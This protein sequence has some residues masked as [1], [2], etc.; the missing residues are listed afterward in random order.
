MPILKDHLNCDPTY[1]LEEMIIEANPLHKK[2]KR[3]AK[4]SSRRSDGHVNP[5]E[6]KDQQ[7]AIEEAF[8]DFHAFN[9]ERESGDKRRLHVTTSDSAIAHHKID[10]DQD[11][12]KKA[13][14]KANSEGATQS[15]R[16]QSST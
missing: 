11:I 9:R 4:Q 15:L 16:V 14:S 3:L 1:E 2:K 7:K 10:L 6:A 5:Q 13:L 12:K 8:N